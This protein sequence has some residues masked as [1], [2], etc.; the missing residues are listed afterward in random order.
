[1]WVNYIENYTTKDAF[2]VLKKTSPPSEEEGYVLLWILE[3][4]QPIEK[5]NSFSCLNELQPSLIQM[6]FS[7]SM[8]HRV[9]E[10]LESF[11]FYSFVEI[12]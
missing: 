7:Y 8:N 5:E 11:K 3:R 9:S 10:M 2:I 12:I 4:Q 6:Q 1:M